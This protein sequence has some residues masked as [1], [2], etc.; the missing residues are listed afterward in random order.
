VALE[1]LF[2]AKPSIN[3]S[4]TLA[5][6]LLQVRRHFNRC[7]ACRGAIKARDFDRLCDDVKDDLLFVASRWDSNISGRLAVRRGGNDL[8]FLCPDPNSHGP[9]YAATA[10]PVIVTHFMEALF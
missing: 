5:V 7:L 4:T 10:E 8:Q 9:A 3:R 6:R 1:V 2:M